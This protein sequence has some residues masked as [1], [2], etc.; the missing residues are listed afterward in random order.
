MATIATFK[1]GANHSA[2]KNFWNKVMWAGVEPRVND[3]H[4]TEK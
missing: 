2:I 4:S 1:A 3:Q